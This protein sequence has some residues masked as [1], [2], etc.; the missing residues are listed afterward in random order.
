MAETFTP[1]LGLIQWGA[2]TDGPTRAEFNSIS[3]ALENLGAIDKQGTFA[4]RPA[5]TVRGTYYWDTT[6][7]ILWRDNSSAWFSVGATG[8]DAVFSSSAIGNRPLTLNAPAGQ[9]ANLLTANVNAV[10]LAEI[11]SSG[12]FISAGTYTGKSLSMVNGTAG[13]VVIDGKGAPSQSADLLRLRNS[14]DTNLFRVDASGNVLGQ[15]FRIANGSAVFGGTAMSTVSG[16]LFSGNAAAEVVGL[17]GGASGTFSDFLLIQHQ[18][19]DS[20]AVLRRLGLHMMVDTTSEAKSGSLY[21][22]SSAA[23]FG[24]PEFVLARGGTPVLRFPSTGNAILGTGIGLTIPTNNDATLAQSSPSF[25]IGAANAANLILS[26]S[27]VVARNNGAAATLALNPEGGTVTMG[28]NLVVTGTITGGGVLQ[29]ISETILGSAQSSVTLSSIPSTYRHLILIMGSRGTGTVQFTPSG[30][31]FNGDTGNNYDYV[32][33]WGTGA[34]GTP[35]PYAGAVQAIQS[36]SIFI[37]ETPGASASANAANSI[38]IHIPWYTAT[39]FQKNVIVSTTMPYAALS[40]G[41]EGSAQMFTEH[42]SGRWRNFSD[43][44]SSITL[45]SATTGGPN[46]FGIGSYFTLYGLP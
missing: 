42:T 8:A 19:A 10:A 34:T 35:A 14:A 31:R 33:L 25:M 32:Q 37:G 5:P 45:L 30:M 41:S 13:N 20:N 26:G 18:A 40:S 28:G 46:N 23:N 9:T 4:S 39:G 43:A 21:I 38:I 2:G 11:T 24:S 16:T 6:N 7:G 1:R 44:I 27:K 29:K 15:S 36:S 22:E 3:S 17:T 12:S